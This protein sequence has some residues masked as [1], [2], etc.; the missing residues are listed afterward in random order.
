MKKL[1][2]VMFMMLVCVST[3]SHAWVKSIV[4]GTI[5][6]VIAGEI[7]KPS[8]AQAS[9]QTAASKVEVMPTRSVTCSYS[10]GRCIL[11]DPSMKELSKKWYGLGWDVSPEQFVAL[12]TRTKYPVKSIRKF[13]DSLL[14]IEY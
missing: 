5:G 7:M 8:P 11:T 2:V 9:L 3:P 1:N 13:D 6:G 14:I 4:S 10:G 12:S